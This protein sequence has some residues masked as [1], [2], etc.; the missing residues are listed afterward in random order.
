MINSLLACE[1]ALL[2]AQIGELARRLVLH[3]F[4]KLNFSHFTP[5]IMVFFVET[6]NPEFSYLKM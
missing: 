2:F 5:Q 1:Q 4:L 6:G 3:D